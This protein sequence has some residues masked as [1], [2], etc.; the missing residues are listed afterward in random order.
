MRE[1][2]T[3]AKVSES[4]N[5]IIAIRRGVRGVHWDDKTVGAQC[6]RSVAA[7]DVALDKN[8]VVGARVDGLVVEVIVEVVVQ[9]LVS[10]STRCGYC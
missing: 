1:R 2:L 7:E 8:L 10:E 6:L 5:L 4:I 3:G 9:M